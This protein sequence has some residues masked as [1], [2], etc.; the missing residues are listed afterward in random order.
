MSTEKNSRTR[1]SG[2][3]KTPIEGQMPSDNV[4][5]DVNDGDQVINLLTGG[6]NEPGFTTRIMTSTGTH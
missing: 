1:K 5:R 4:G 3:S 6:S 2:N